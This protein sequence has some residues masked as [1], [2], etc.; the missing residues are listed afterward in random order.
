MSSDSTAAQLPEHVARDLHPQDEVS[1][2]Q[3]VEADPECT[4]E[5]Q[6]HPSHRKIREL[7]EQGYLGPDNSP[8]PRAKL[9]PYPSDADR[10]CAAPATFPQLQFPAACSE[11]PSPLVCVPYRRKSES[12]P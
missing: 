4:D 7:E 3:E 1:H 8:R 9:T 12:G 11:F 2:G 6:S 5:V 10:R